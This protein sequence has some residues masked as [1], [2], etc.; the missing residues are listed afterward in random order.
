MEGKA[1]LCA[2]WRRCGCGLINI[3][4]RLCYFVYRC[5]EPLTF[6]YVE[7]VGTKTFMT[8]APSP[9]AN[10]KP[11]AT[12]SLALAIGGMT[13]A[14]CAG[15]IERGLCA[16]DGVMAANVNLVLERA[17]VTINPA[18]TNSQAVISVIHD[19]G[20]DATLLPTIT[21]RLEDS[22]STWRDSL[23]VLCAAALTAPLVAQMIAHTVNLNFHLSMWTEVALASPV[24][25]ILGARFYAGSY[26][27]LKARAPNMD[28]LVALGTSAAY[29]FSLAQVWRSG[30]NATGHLY[31]ESSAVILTLVLLGKWLEAR[32]KRSTTDAIRALMKLRPDTARVLRNGLEQEIPV[33]DVLVNDVVMIRPG[34]K[35]PTDGIITQGNSTCDESLVTGESIP[36]DKVAGD[37]VIAGAMNGAGLIMVRTTAV[38][39]DSTLAK[40]IA[41]VQS[42]QTGKAPVQK[43]VDRISAI[44]VPVII[45]A[46]LTTFASWLLVGQTLEYAFITAV[47]VL[48][49]ACP[50]ALGLATPTALVAGL[51]AAARA[52]ILIKDIEALERIHDVSTIVFDKTGTLTNGKPTVTQ[53]IT[54]AGDERENIS[55]AASLQNAS[56]HPLAKAV[57]GFA[58]TRSAQMSPITDFKAHPG[59]G[60]EA[61][62][63]QSVVFM[64]NDAFAR[65]HNIKLVIPRDV[66]DQTIAILG[67]DGKARAI[68]A[69]AD[70]LRVTSKAAISALHAAGFETWL[71]SG[72]RK[73]VAEKIGQELGIGRV[74]AEILPAQKAREI[75][76]IRSLGKGV[77]MVGDGINDAPALATADVGIAMGGGTD[78]AMATAG[79]TLLRP[80]PRLVGAAIDI[81]RATRR[82]IRENLF[83]AFVF[84]LIGVPLAALGFLNPA[85]A[86]AAMALSSVS[87]VTNALRLKR[88]RPSFATD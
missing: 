74:M 5:P 66:Q 56:E 71:L 87:V 67:V 79:I 4:S 27:A 13:C 17:E 85:I 65:E 34:E 47:A 48:V 84:N 26:R 38:G 80:D 25:F 24:Q 33:S 7:G 76:N 88:W 53:M 78:V 50:C 22:P 39:E 10:N 3:K 14:A 73:A 54:L 30:A 11:L 1:S 21:T 12:R 2:K 68:F 62:I 9:E 41:I 58:K 35:I 31:F 69:I 75:E 32:A 81:G 64:G 20:F 51:G 86:G 36:V 29:F 52:G 57:L 43:L 60:V 77:V 44:F 45:L 40:I 72:D 59:R 16:L 42:A 61:R 28:V 15:R 55:L 83:W 46:S 63:D 82:I 70:S 19:T 23:A 6:Q 37:R 18:R 8:T 49:I